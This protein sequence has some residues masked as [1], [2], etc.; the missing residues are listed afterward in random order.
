[1][2]KNGR[3]LAVQVDAGSI[4]QVLADVGVRNSDVLFSDAIVFVEGPGDRDVLTTWC[5]TLGESLAER[6]ISVLPMGGGDFS[7]QKVVPRKEALEAIAGNATVP[8][9][10]V[11]DRDERPD[12]EISHLQKS[13][14]EAVYFLERRELENY[15]LTPAALLGTIKAKL[16]NTGGPLAAIDAAVPAEIEESIL[17]EAKKLYG[18]VLLK[19]I[20]SRVLAFKGGGIFPREIV[21]T[22]AAEAKNPK[23]DEILGERLQRRSAE[24]QDCYELPRIVS[25]ER[26]KLEEQWKHPENLLNL[27]PGSELIELVFRKFGTEY[28]KPADTRTVAAGMSAVKFPKK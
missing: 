28:S 16:Q 3:S 24:L 26:E 14:G 20:R 17:V 18:T 7:N 6:N 8:H 2:M 25:E 21:L 4:A 15:M 23:L 19:R 10:F 27:A 5:T 13:L 22:L 1:V 11:F 9:L 12:E